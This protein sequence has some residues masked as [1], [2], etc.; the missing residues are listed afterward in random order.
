[1]PFPP[2]RAAI[3]VT[4]SAFDAVDADLLV[5]P[6]FDGDAAEGPSGCKAAPRGEIGRAVSSGEFSGHR[7]DVFVT[8]VADHRWKVARVALV[9][10]GT[11]TDFV[12]DYVRRAASAP[13]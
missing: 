9:G 11:R 4:T 6:W 2:A 10:L 12:T 5:V 8:P 7:Y 13:G 1:M 3:A